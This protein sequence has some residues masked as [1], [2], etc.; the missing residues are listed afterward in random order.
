MKKRDKQG[1]K[2]QL[3]GKQE[4]RQRQGNNARLSTKQENR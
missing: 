1:L 4:T 2:N 3:E